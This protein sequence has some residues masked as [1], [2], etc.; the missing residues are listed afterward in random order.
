MLHTSDWTYPCSIV[1]DHHF[2][3]LA[4]HVLPMN[5]MDASCWKEG[6]LA[7]KE[8]THM[9]LCGTTSDR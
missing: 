1:A 6:A 9:D 2:S 4:V 3:P 5:R 8:H 7:A